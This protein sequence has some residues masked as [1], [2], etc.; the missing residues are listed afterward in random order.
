MRRIIGSLVIVLVAAACDGAAVLP[1]TPTASRPDIRIHESPSPFDE[2]T[3][4]E[5]R[6]LI[7]DTWHPQLTDAISDAEQGLIASPHPRD[8]ASSQ[9]PVEGMAAMWV[10]GTRVGVPSDYYYLAATG[11]ALDLL[12]HSAQCSATSHTVFV[13][14]RPAFANGTAGSPGDYVARG[15]GV[16]TVGRRPTRWAYFIAAPGYG[17]VRSVGIP[18]SGLY[19]VVA[20][21]RDSPRASGLLDKLLQRTAFGGTTVSDLIAVARGQLAA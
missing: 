19:V 3:A 12:T 18:S 2:V 16:C 7:P 10:D 4:G 1:M 17:P 20:V 6:A 11:P 5:I 14:H 8:W 21:L 13:D 15:Q 9:A